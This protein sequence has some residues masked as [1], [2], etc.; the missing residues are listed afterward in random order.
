MEVTTGNVVLIKG[1]DKHSGKWN[2]CIV[3]ELYEGK[4]SMTRAVKTSVEEDIH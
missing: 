3:G 4:D 1:D 2:I